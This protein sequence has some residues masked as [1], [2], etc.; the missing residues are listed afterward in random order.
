MS[1]LERYLSDQA[2]H[3]FIEDDAQLAVIQRLT[4]L[5]EGLEA[6]SVQK[7]VA[8]KGFF[9][10]F[11]SIEPSILNAPKGLYLWGGVGQ[12]KTYLMDIFYDSLP[13]KEKQ[14]THFH[15]FMQKVHQQLNGIKNVEDPLQIVA[16]QIAS[17][18]RVLCFDEFFVSD[19]TDAMLLGRLFEAL[20]KR[21]ICLVATSNI[22]P[23]GL[24]KGGLQRARFLPAIEALKANCDVLKLDSGTDYRLRELEQAEIYHSP[25]DD[26]AD[27]VL[28]EL[29]EHMTAA[30]VEPESNLEIEGR[31]VGVEHC[32]E[33]V[34]WFEYKTICDIPRGAADY[35]EISRLFHTVFVSNVTVMND[36]TNDI[37]NRFIN[38]VDELYDHNVKLIISAEVPVEQLYQGT[39]LAFQFER[40]T[41]RLLEM[42]SHDYLERPHLP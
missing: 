27:I 1:P 40:T 36:M 30:D 28:S 14:R 23:D 18:S 31:Q 41:S 33:G 25:L 6:P 20:F 8:K 2:Q 32:A 7:T 16:D 22:E 13:F 11:K 3:G 37:A 38:L 17:D 35:I 39:K 21:G 9:S 15:R 26:Q 29:F 34:V 19:I 5:Y 12:G 24:Y 4:E 42:Q 10:K